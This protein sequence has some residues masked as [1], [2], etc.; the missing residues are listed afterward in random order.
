M[1]FHLKCQ[2]E[3]DECGLNANNCYR[4]YLQLKYLYKTALSSQFIP[5]VRV[6]AIQDLVH[7]F[8]SRFFLHLKTV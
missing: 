6:K 8:N 5:V 3:I 1:S 2:V 7:K 4:R